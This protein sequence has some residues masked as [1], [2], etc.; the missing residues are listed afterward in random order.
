MAK[1]RERE[2]RNWTLFYQYESFCY[3][4]L[5]RDKNLFSS[6]EILRKRCVCEIMER[7][8]RA[9]DFSIY[10][11]WNSNDEYSDNS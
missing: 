8:F 1:W 9:L 10:W 4:Q 2:E 3:F 5:K 11:H 7:W 6:V